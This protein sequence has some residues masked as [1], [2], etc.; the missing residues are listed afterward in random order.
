[1]DK[2]T[3]PPATVGE[4]IKRSPAEVRTALQ[5]LRKT[6]KTTAPEA[7][8]VIS[9]AIPGY[10]YHGMLIFFAAFK[11]HISV[12]PAPRGNEAFKKELAAYKGGKGTIQFPLGEPIPF[13]LVVRIIKFRMKENEER[14]AAK[15]KK[16]LKES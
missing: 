11:N 9:Y 10:K 3:K 12:Y 7:E 15:N 8:E 13:D 2:R 1:M 16:I 5:K 14:A 6:I 4:Y